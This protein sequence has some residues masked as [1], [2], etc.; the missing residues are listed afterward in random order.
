MIDNF[1]MLDILMRISGIL[2]FT[3]PIIFFVILA[4]YYINKVGKTREGMMVLIGNILIFIVAVI[5]QFLYLLIDALGY[6]IFSFINITINFISF[7]GS[8]LF[9]IG[10]YFIIKKVINTTKLK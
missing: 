1:D 7:I 3:L 6:E 5:H 2:F 8:V 4:V 9:L 10:F